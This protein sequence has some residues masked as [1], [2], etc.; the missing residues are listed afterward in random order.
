MNTSDFTV[1]SPGALPNIGGSTNSA[2]LFNSKDTD[3]IRYRDTLKKWAFLIRTLAA[4]DKKYE[5][6]LQ[7]MGVMIYMSCDQHAQDLLTRAEKNRVLNLEGSDNDPKREKLVE[8]ILSVIAQETEFDRVAR[9]VELMEGLI[10]CERGQGEEI[11]DFV[12]RFNAAISL[13]TKHVGILTAQ[14]TRHCISLLFKNAKLPYDSF[15]AAITQ[16][17]E[18]QEKRSKS[19]PPETN[20]MI[21]QRDVSKLLDTVKK[22]E[23]HREDKIDDGLKELLEQLQRHVTKISKA[24]IVDIE[25]A[26]EFTI[27]KA[28]NIVSRMKVNIMHTSLLGSSEAIAS[29]IN[30]MKRK[31]VCRACNE[32]GHW[33]KDRKECRDKIMSIRAESRPIKKNS[34]KSK[35]ENKEGKGRKNVRFDLYSDNDSESESEGTSKKSSER[36]GPVNRKTRGSLLASQTGIRNVKAELTNPIID[37]GA[38]KN[39]G[40]LTNVARLCDALGITLEISSPRENYIHGWGDTCENARPIVGTWYLTINDINGNPTCF[41]FDV[42]KGEMPILLGLESEKHSDSQSLEKPQTITYLRPEIDKEKRVFY[43]YYDND[44]Y[45]NERKWIELVPHEKSTTCSLMANVVSRHDIVLAKKLH[46]YS[47]AGY[48]EMKKILEVWYV[49]PQNEESMSECN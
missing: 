4:T 39:I 43:V 27:E 25:T 24:E 29:R 23:A 9:E 34:Y 48:N 38:P 28:V 35:F 21:P 47:H 42:V 13:Y 41:P 7:S 20:R 40:G 18:F 31:S 6:I 45:G 49:D 19:E 16:W 15:N 36:N 11:K 32:P 8:Q 3:K 2:P 22:I 33:W 44:Q 10:N 17:S 46:R 14:T 12:N 37:E 26:E 5:G 30:E 1:M